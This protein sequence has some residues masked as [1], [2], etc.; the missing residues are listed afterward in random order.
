MPETRNPEPGTRNP[1]PYT[2]NLKPYTPNPNL[3]LSAS[4]AH[5][6]LMTSGLGV[7]IGNWAQIW[8]LAFGVCPRLRTAR[9]GHGEN[10]GGVPC[11][12]TLGAWPEVARCWVER[13]K[14]LTLT[15]WWWGRVRVARGQGTLRGVWPHAPGR[16]PQGS[17]TIRNPMPETRNPEP[18]TR[19]PE[20]YTLNLK[21]YTPNP[22]LSLSASLA[23]PS[24]ISSGYTPA[25]A[26]VSR[27]YEAG[28]RV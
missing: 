20:P 9:R 22:N 12:G 27:I 18:G 3:S 17:Q 4:I 5:P 2:L 16:P 21:P 11:L 28:C 7:G 8:G 14:V 15:W 26:I 1:E 24:L 23:H 25:A 10:V 6:S 19:N 13:W